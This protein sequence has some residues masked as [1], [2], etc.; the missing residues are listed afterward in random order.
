MLPY[1][2]NT[3]LHIFDLFQT[4]QNIAGYNMKLIINIATK[5]EM[6]NLITISIQNNIWKFKSI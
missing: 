3:W 6:L 5:N 2:Y 1:K 4:T